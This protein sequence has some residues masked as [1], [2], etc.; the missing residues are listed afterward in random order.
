MQRSLVFPPKQVAIHCPQLD[1]HVIRRGDRDPSRRLASLL[2]YPSMDFALSAVELLDP[3]PAHDIQIRPFFDRR[4]SW[5][6]LD[7]LQ[8]PIR[9]PY[10]GAW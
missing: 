3:D 5:I 6:L 8:K 9:C 7:G 1:F 4:G 2:P 10:S